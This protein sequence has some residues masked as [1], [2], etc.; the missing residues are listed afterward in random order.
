MKCAI[1][2]GNLRKEVTKLELWVDGKLS[3][4]E[5]VPAKVCE[6][7]GEK[8]FSAKVSKQID[9]LLKRKIKAEKKVE[10]PV[11]SFKALKA[12]G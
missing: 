1:C 8:Y 12:I 7:C 2:S 5:D 9:K 4:I 11:F 10:V 6:N 3:I